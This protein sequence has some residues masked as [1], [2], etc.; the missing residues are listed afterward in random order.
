MEP[1]FEAVRAPVVWD[2]QGESYWAVVLWEELVLPETSKTEQLG[3]KARSL[4][5]FFLYLQGHFLSDP[6]AFR[7]RQS[8]LFR[9]FGG[10]PLAHRAARPGDD[11]CKGW[12][13]AWWSNG[14]MGFLGVP[15]CASQLTDGFYMF[16]PSFPRKVV[17]PGREKKTDFWMFVQHFEWKI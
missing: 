4:P 7:L 15:K 13:L 16:L 2:D 9:P 12:P 5:D 14:A 11:V 1:R 8:H 17:F 10:P 6:T 3:N